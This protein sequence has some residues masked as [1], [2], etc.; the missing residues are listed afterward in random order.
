MKMRKYFTF[1]QC[2]K[3]QFQG[4]CKHL[5]EIINHDSVFK[6]LLRRESEE[7]SKSLMKE[8]KDYKRKCC[9]DIG[10][11]SYSGFVLYYPDYL[12]RTYEDYIRSRSSL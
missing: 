8:Y 10:P 6:K 4:T 12:E 11:L 5:R 2:S 1:I 7:F 3:I 9:Q